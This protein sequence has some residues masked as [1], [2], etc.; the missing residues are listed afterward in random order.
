MK[1]KV[2]ELKLQCFSHCFKVCWYFSWPNS[3]QILL[4]IRIRLA[5]G[6]K[7]SLN[8]EQN[9]LA[10]RVFL[11]CFLTATSAASKPPGINLQLQNCFIN[12]PT[13]LVGEHCRQYCQL[14]QLKWFCICFKTGLLRY[15]HLKNTVMNFFQV[16]Q[17]RLG[18]EMYLN[19]W[20]PGI[21]VIVLELLLN[22]ST[23][24][25]LTLFF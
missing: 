14:N 12:K 10:P 18:L 21:Y 9:V 17:I 19:E 16:E 25:Q 24:I 11:C 3:W 5:D 8:F 22:C 20:R 23:L 15:V 4:S 2:N 13:D 6:S 7:E 1:T